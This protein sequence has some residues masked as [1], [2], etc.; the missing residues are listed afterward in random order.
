MR[1]ALRE[2]PVGGAVAAR[3]HGQVRDLDAVVEPG[4]AQPLQVAV[5]VGHDLDEAV[6][7]VLGEVEPERVEQRLVTPASAS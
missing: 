4:V 6:A 5:A 2:G 1:G 3:L 7:A